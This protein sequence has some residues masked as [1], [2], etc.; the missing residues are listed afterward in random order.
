VA[1]GPN[2]GPGVAVGPGPTAVA[3]TGTPAPAFPP[4]FPPASSGN[5]GSGSK[6]LVPAKAQASSGKPLPGAVLGWHARPNETLLGVKPIKDQELVVYQYSWM[7]DVLPFLGYEDL[8]NEFDFKQPWTG[9][10]SLRAAT[11]IVPQFQNPL[12]DRQRWKGYPFQGL[13]LT[14][15]TGISGIEDKRNV[16]AAELPRSDP[17]AGVFGY[18]G[19]AKPSEITDGTSNTLMMI[20]AGELAAPWVQGGGATVRGAR[21]PYF[22]K[23]SGFG[24]RGGSQPGSMAMMADGSVRQI[25]ANIDPKVFR[26]MC[27]IHGGETVDLAPLGPSLADFPSK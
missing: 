25:P 1:S 19:V 12:D 5:S 15:F 20:G 27:T 26:A 13:A 4:S 16:L 23:L 14:H 9:G 24:T 18:R 17:R 7:C 2:V 11:G 8:Y 6:T 22:D 3:T 10:K 21:E